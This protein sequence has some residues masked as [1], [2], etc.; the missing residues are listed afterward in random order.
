MKIIKP[1]ISNLDEK[2]FEMFSIITGIFKE[3]DKNINKKDL[4]F[5]ECIFEKIDI[6][7][8]DISRS[9]FID[10]IFQEFLFF[11]HFFKSG[12]FLK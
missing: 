5:D 11:L 6:I 10:V 3:Q 9:E 7:D 2:E 4:K 12:I 1:K 8:S